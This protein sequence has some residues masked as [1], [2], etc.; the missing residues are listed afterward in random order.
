MLRRTPFHARTGPLNESSAWRRWAGHIAA[1][2][3]DLTHDHEYA[4]IRGAAG[5]I[6]VSPL[7][8]YRVT[9]TDAARLL[10]RV[11]TRDVSKCAVGQVYYT[12]W[13]DGDGKVRR[14]INLYKNDE[15]V[16]ALDGQATAVAADDTIAIVPAIAGG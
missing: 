15:D 6:D 1:S 4:A 9:G 5:L 11:V 14:F 7:Y 2:S 3:Y 10:D 8:K 13:C 16:R 12:P